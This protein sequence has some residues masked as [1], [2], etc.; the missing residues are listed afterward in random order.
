MGIAI[1]EGIGIKILA[2]SFDR[3][4]RSP[5]DIENLGLLQMCDEISTLR[6]ALLDLGGPVWPTDYQPS[7]IRLAENYGEYANA[8]MSFI[9]GGRK[10]HDSLIVKLREAS[11]EEI[12]KDIKE[13]HYSQNLRTPKGSWHSWEIFGPEKE[14]R[15]LELSLPHE[16]LINEQVAYSPTPFRFLKGLYH[17]FQLQPGQVVWDLGCGCGHPS[18][19]GAINYPNVLFKGIELIP[20]GVQEGERIKKMLG[21]DNVEF[22]QGN[23]L[24]TDIS[25]GDA[26]YMFNPFS[27]DTLGEVSRRLGELGK[28]K[29]IKVAHLGSR[30]D[31]LL[32]SSRLGETFG[33]VH[34]G[35]VDRCPTIYESAKPAGVGS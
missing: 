15:N 35:E 20:A 25:D 21:L 17:E 10:K 22:Y 30:F 32:D 28:T 14:I 1:D 8:V 7:E 29:N 6:C 34:P 26:F 4:R 13:Y 9:Q 3:I 24:D 31:E 23:V 19:Y 33:E 5:K 12:R 18:I 27:D 11:P 2:R 16:V